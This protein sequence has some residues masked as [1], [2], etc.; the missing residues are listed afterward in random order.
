[1]GVM[2]LQEPESNT[3]EVAKELNGLFP[4]SSLVFDVREA[5]FEVLLFERPRFWHNDRRCF[6]KISCTNHEYIPDRWRLLG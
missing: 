4:F 3:D 5:I 1:M 2:R 6:H